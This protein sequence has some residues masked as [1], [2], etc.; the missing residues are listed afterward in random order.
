V[1]SCEQYTRVFKLI[2]AGSTNATQINAQPCY[3]GR[4]VVYNAAAA[5]RFLK[6]YD[7]SSGLVVGTT[8]PT[9][10]IGIGT[11]LTANVMLGYCFKNGLAIAT[12][13]LITDAD[14]TAVTLNDMAI[15]IFIR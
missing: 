7:I 11:L 15:N 2:S 14:A 5:A 9:I 13:T 10:T 8:V 4:I 6:L 1:I 12:T 3:V